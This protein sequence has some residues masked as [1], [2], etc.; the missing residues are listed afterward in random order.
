[1]SVNQV[2]PNRQKLTDEDARHLLAD[3]LLRICHKHGPSKVSV[4]AGC[5]EKTIRR[6]RDEES[7]LN[8]ACSWNLLDI[9]PHALDALAAA[10][11]VMLVPLMASGTDVIPAAGAAIHC[12]GKNRS[13]GSANGHIETDAELIASE[14]ENDALLA[15]VLERRSEISRAKLRR[16]A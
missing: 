16:A 1:V 15:A 2:R 6:A 12:I 13:T 8:L 7:T 3:G 5:D 10:K 11:G 9:D 14:D 4:E